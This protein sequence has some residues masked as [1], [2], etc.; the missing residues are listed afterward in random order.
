MFCFLDFRMTSLEKSVSS[1]N[2]QHVQSKF[3]QSLPQPIHCWILSF[4]E[5][6]DYDAL[7]S[8]SQSLNELTM[9]YFARMKVLTITGPQLPRVTHGLLS[10][11][12]KHA[13]SLQRIFL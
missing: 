8:T 11:I 10:T 9:T 12:V 3:S 7:L 1:A 13:C 5:L 2:L 6:A 4:L